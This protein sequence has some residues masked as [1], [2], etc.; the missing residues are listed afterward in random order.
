LARHTGLSCKHVRSASDASERSLGKRCSTA[1]GKRA[2]SEGEQSSLERTV[3]VEGKSAAS[4]FI[5]FT[6]EQ[7]KAA[8]VELLPVQLAEE[9]KRQNAVHLLLREQ[10]LQLA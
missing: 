8:I 1:T 10:R 2:A 9:L 6:R 3:R 5:S 4:R 7:L